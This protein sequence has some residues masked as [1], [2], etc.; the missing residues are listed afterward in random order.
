MCLISNNQIHSK[1]N[2]Y[3]TEGEICV[4]F[5]NWLAVCCY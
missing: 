1:G 3:S 4:A 2:S 5:K